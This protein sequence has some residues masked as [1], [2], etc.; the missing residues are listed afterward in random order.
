MQIIL[1]KWR[2]LRYLPEFSVIKSFTAANISLDPT[3]CPGADPF[4]E[5]NGIPIQLLG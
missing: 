3:N 4:G 1:E 2:S 5:A